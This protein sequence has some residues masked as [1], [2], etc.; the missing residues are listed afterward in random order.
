MEWILVRF[1]AIRD[2]FVDGLRWGPTNKLLNVGAGQ[3]TVHLGVP[4]SYAP[5]V[6]RGVVASTTPTVPVQIDFV[7]V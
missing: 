3:H 1:P 7:S 6:W 4:V 2:V 5:R